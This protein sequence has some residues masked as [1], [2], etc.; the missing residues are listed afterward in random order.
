M[1]AAACAA[2]S[3]ASPAAACSSAAAAEEVDFADFA[4]PGAVAA[5]EEHG[6]EEEVE[7]VVTAFGT[8]VVD[9]ASPS[10][11]RSPTSPS[12]V[13]SGGRGWLY[14]PEPGDAGSFEE[15]GAMGEEDEV[16]EK[17]RGEVEELVE[18]VKAFG[19]TIVVEPDGAD[20][21][22]MDDEDEDDVDGFMGGGAAGSFMMGGDS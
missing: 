20:E 11:C 4:S 15:M 10:P 16:L 14:A 18:E 8:F 2:I 12:S 3:L 17:E 7:R 21:V 13:S 22:D 19:T 9:E 1:P 6:G 5:L